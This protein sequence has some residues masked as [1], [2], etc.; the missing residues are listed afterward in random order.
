MFVLLPFGCPFA[1]FVFV[2]FTILLNF[3]FAL[4][5]CKRAFFECY[6]FSFPFP[7]CSFFHNFHRLLQCWSECVPFYNKVPDLCVFL[8][9]STPNCN[10]F[11]ITESR[12]DSRISDQDINIQ[13]IVFREKI[14][15]L[16]DRF[17]LQYT[18]TTLLLTIHTGVKT[19]KVIFLNAFGLN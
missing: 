12:L 1:C 13:I 11:G 7:V 6:C 15:L 5:L 3:G 18:Y 17:V 9:Q 10:I 4:S 16:L 14:H 19:L 8:S 2:N